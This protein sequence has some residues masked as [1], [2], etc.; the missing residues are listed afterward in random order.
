[1]PKTPFPSISN[2][3]N[4]AGISPAPNC[5]GKCLVSRHVPELLAQSTGP[6]AHACFSTAPA[7]VC[8]VCSV[9]TE[10]KC[11]AGRSNCTIEQGPGCRTRDI[12]YFNERGND[13]EPGSTDLIWCLPLAT[14]SARCGGCVPSPGPGL[15]G[16]GKSSYSERL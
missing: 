11:K 6:R 15:R 5:V 1:M 2:S 3:S 8:M 7:T 13:I 4:L 16:C 10:G 14:G 9:F 12:F